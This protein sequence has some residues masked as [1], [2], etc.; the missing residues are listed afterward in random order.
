M[1]THEELKAIALSDP[2]T[3]AAY[4]A[5]EEEFILLGAMLKARRDAGMSQNDVAKSMSTKQSSVAR[6]ES[7]GGSNKHSPSIST[8]RKYAKA[9]GCALDVRF[10]PIDGAETRQNQLL[11]AD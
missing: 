4:D 1:R 2:I 11:R 6:I 10:V 9:V 7:N 5:L 3:K 8:L